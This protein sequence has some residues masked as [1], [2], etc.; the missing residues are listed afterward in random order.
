MFWLGNAIVV[1]IM[2][3]YVQVRTWPD[4]ASLGIERL[5]NRKRD[6]F[7]LGVCVLKVSS[8]SSSGLLGH[9]LDLGFFFVRPRFSESVKCPSMARPVVVADMMV[10]CP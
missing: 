1:H 10:P 7:F 6:F 3:T 2:T 9:V 5:T 4:I 8:Q